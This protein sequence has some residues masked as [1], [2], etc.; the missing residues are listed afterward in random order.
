MNGFV[1]FC[2]HL[3][4]MTV[5]YACNKCILNESINVLLADFETLYREAKGRM[6]EEK[7]SLFEEER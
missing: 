7:H 6:A 3:N 4:I 5:V 1:F 2:V